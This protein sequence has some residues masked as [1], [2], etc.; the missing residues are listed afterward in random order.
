[1]DENLW[2]FIAREKQHGLR[3]INNVLFK[4]RNFDFDL[5]SID[6]DFRDEWIRGYG[7]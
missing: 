4:S 7:S 1:M 3:L 5:K 6:I 2:N